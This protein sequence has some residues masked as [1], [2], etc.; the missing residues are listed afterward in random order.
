LP[1]LAGIRIIFASGSADV[2]AV[3]R[4]A[5]SSKKTP[6][7][8]RKRCKMKNRSRFPGDFERGQG[9]ENMSLPLSSANLCGAFRLI[10]HLEAWD[11]SF[12]APRPR[13]DAPPFDKDGIFA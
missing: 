9:L 5:F 4:N 10:H 3:M 13:R 11:I 12:E 6:L 7:G 8:V 1:D 2:W